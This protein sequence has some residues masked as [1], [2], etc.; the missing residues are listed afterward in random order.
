MAI[1][2]TSTRE[3]DSIRPPQ[4]SHLTLG[5]IAQNWIPGSAYERDLYRDP[6]KELVR[7][8]GPDFNQTVPGLVVNEYMIL[9]A[10]KM[11][12][13]LSFAEGYNKRYDVLSV[14]N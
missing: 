2:E 7:L 14:T 4:F 5:H 13:L 3:I 10:G 12:E 9:V 8:F 1:S 6:T 11:D